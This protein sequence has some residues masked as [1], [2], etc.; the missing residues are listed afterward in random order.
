[1]KLKSKEGGIIKCLRKVIFVMRITIF[2]ILL[3]SVFAFSTNSYSQNKKLSMRLNNASVGDALKAI[4]N[5][6]EFIFFYQD[7]KI[8]LNRSVNIVVADKTVNEI[9]DQLFKGSDNVYKIHDRQI[10]IGKSQNQLEIKGLP[11]ER[12]FEELQMQPQKK[13]L[14]GKVTDSKGGPIPGIAVLVKGTTIGT[15]TDTEGNFSMDVPLNAE[16]LLFSFVG[17]KTQEIPIAGK[18]TFNIVMAEETFGV[19]EVV[20]V[21]YGTM[22]KSDLTGAVS[23]I[24]GKDLEDQSLGSITES[25]QGRAAGVSVMQDSGEPG[26]GINIKI[27]GTNSLLGD[28]TPL[29][30][31]DGLPVS[32][33]SN[34]TESL[35]LGSN[36]L[37]N[38]NPDDIESI[39]ILKDASAIAIYG[40]RAS[41]GVVLIT[42]KQAQSGATQIDI[43]TRHSVSQVKNFYD[44]ISGPDYARLRNENMVF[45]RLP[46]TYEEELANGRLPYDGL[47][48]AGEPDPL[49]PLPENAPEGVNMY[50]ALFQLGFVQDYDLTISG[51]TGNY[52]QLVGINYSDQEGN[53]I[54]SGF[55]RGGLK[56][57]SSLKINDKLTLKSTLNL[58][59]TQKQRINTSFESVAG[60]VIFGMFRY[61]PFLGLTTA[62]DIPD[63]DDTGQPIL[64]PYLEIVGRDY[65]NKG[66]DAL[67]NFQL[68]YMLTKNLTLTAR[69]GGSYRKSTIDDYQS[70]LTRTGYSLNGSLSKNLL[71]HNSLVSEV[72]MNHI[73][74]KGNHRLNSTLGVSYENVNQYRLN[75]SWIDFTFHDMSYFAPQ[76]SLQ[77]MQYI[78]IDSNY[79]L[80]SGF[81]R[82]NY[83]FNSRYL[84]TFTGRADGSSKFSEGGRWGFFPTGA[85]AWNAY[86][87]NFIKNLGVFSNLKL[88]ASYGQTGNQAIQ[89]YS[90]LATIESQK[91]AMGLGQLFTGSF[92]ARIA[93]KQLTWETTTSF[94]AGLEMG[95]FNDKI[96]FEIDYYHKVTDDLLMNLPIPVQTGFERIAKNIGSLENEGLELTIYTYPVKF[97][98]FSWSTNFNISTNKTTVTNLGGL[99]YLETGR[100]GAGFGDSPTRLYEGGTLGEF[101]VYECNRLSHLSDF[102]DYVNDETHQIKQ[103]V[104]G[105]DEEGNDIMG[106]SFIPF[107]DNVPGVWVF[108]DQNGD[109]V[110]NEDDKILQGNANPDFIF[111]WS[112][113]FSYKNFDLSF[114]LQGSYGNDV[115]NVTDMMVNGASF[116][117]PDKEYLQ[118]MWTLENPHNNPKYPAF[119][120]NI[121]DKLSSVQIE[122]GSYVRLKNLTLKYNFNTSKISFLRNFSIYFSGSNLFTLTNYTGQDPEVNSKGNNILAPGID[123]GAYPRPKTYTIG[124]NVKL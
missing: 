37:S 89:P 17:M 81:F 118:N 45:R 54:Q 101:F 88:R 43:S 83:S 23:K 6:S 106:P 114:L 51:G 5:Q 108:E 21:G 44:R 7:Q 116:A 57:N 31:V 76:M 41:N 73:L 111:G 103:V 61:D 9:L 117:V 90:T 27:R 78:G 70:K 1:M 87:E 119:G 47:N 123:F 29:Y 18:M 109:G 62:K 42:T 67:A 15:I 102:V 97:G 94:D 12:I 63:L 64:N 36:P 79:T 33:T 14:N 39:E 56:Y 11:V 66:N 121:N 100:I 104:V 85:F 80:K 52:K 71:E 65:I 13:N 91:M 40:S 8:D 84:L 122:D 24:R 60:G 99:E 77:P 72:F 53:M 124:L 92:P 35:Y 86:K 113:T 32:A 82:L 3:G 95:F 22:K 69:L 74:Q 25:L 48:D 75:Q 96:N 58:T 4:E 10:V 98:A 50:D 34:A 28:N 115:L 112:N 120:I 30:V 26:A 107:V 2:F 93:N 68:D 55:K 46:T 110:I 59:H 38:L 49:T 20:V 19:D 105:K 16:T